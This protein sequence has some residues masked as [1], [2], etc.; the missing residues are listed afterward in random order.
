MGPLGA[1]IA[2][3]TKAVQAKQEEIGELEQQWLKEQNEL[4][5]QMNERDSLTKTVERL[6]KQ[7]TILAQKKLRMD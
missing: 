3:L 1:M 2:N 6:R 7:L 4:V 5:R